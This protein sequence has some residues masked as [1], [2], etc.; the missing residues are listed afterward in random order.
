MTFD[1][2]GSAGRELRLSQA[3]SASPGKYP[4]NSRIVQ[5]LRCRKKSVRIC[6]NKREYVRR[7]SL[8]EKFL[9]DLVRFTQIWSDGLFHSPEVQLGERNCNSEVGQWSVVSSQWV[10]GD[11]DG[12][13]L[14]AK[15]VLQCNIN[16]KVSWNSQIYVQQNVQ[17]VCNILRRCATRGVK[18]EP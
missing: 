2:L 16:D 5:G 9:S 1:G 14:G 17:H 6:A 13:G 8:G 7:L 4:G 11:A 15:N 18:H 12:E 10:K 3:I